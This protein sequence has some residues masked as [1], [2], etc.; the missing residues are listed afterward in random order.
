[1]MDG[2]FQLPGHGQRIDH[3]VDAEMPITPEAG[4]RDVVR[5]TDADEDTRGRMNR[6][7][8]RFVISAGTE[9]ANH[10]TDLRPGLMPQTGISSAS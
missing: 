3:R 9:R 5:G 7:L 8:Y 10:G 1:M 6:A 2:L 4:G